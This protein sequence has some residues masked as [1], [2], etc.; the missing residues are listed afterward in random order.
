MTSLNTDAAGAHARRRQPRV[1]VGR[2][3]AVAPGEREHAPVVD[4]DHDRRALNRIGLAE[5]MLGGALQ[6]GIEGELDAPAVGER[7]HQPTGF[8][9]RRQAAGEGAAPVD[10][11]LL[12]QGHRGGAD[13]PDEGEC[14]EPEEPSRERQAAHE[15]STKHR[16]YQ[17]R[18]TCNCATTLTLRRVHTRALGG[19]GPR[20]W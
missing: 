18:L 3:G 16:A 14:A 7:L 15:R 11:R 20:G 19:A 2:R 17:R 1:V 12:A 8:G 4:G 13:E 10:R 6:L 9:A 5:E